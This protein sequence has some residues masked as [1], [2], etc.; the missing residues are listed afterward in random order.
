MNPQDVI[1]LTPPGLH[2]SLAIAACRAGARGF[3]DLE[4]ADV[5]GALAAVARL[6]QFIAGRFGL[7]IGRDDCALLTNIVGNP[8]RGLAWVLLPGGQG[9]EL[10]SQIA[11]FRER[12]IEVV[13][14]RHRRSSAGREPWGERRYSQGSGS[15][16]P[17]RLGNGF[18]PVAALVCRAT[19]GR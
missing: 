5:D 18:H 8:P 6:Q 9:Q 19:G 13:L 2:P 4:H 17:G 1:V 12:Q 15:R 16:W 3:L 11:L 7:K 10:E 14:G